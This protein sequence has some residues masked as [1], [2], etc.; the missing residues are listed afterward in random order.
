MTFDTT[1]GGDAAATTSTAELWYTAHRQPL[2]SVRNND[3]HET[4][5]APT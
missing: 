1:I 2:A 5:W 3:M 4:L